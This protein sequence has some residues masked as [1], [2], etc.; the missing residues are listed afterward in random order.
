MSEAPAAAAGP[1]PLHV[2][3]RRLLG[4]V[5]RRF[6]VDTFD[7]F[8]RAVL[9]A[10]REPE[11]VPGYDLGWATAADIEG[12]DPY[13]TELDERERSAGVARLGFGHRAVAAWHAGRV[14]FTMW[15]NPRNLNVPGH[16]KRR[17]GDHQ[18]FIYK[19]YTSPD[20]R[21]KSLYKAGMRFVLAEMAAAGLTQLIGYA[22]VKKGVSRKGLAR[23]EFESLGRFRT[24]DVP[25]WRRT[26]PDS[27]LV[28][29][30][31]EALP[32]SAVLA[33]APELVS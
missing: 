21:G 2:R 23:L 20:H 8:G 17:L 32:R 9:P 7:V 28:R 16:V 26:F 4:R 5:R 3:T 10:D 1:L 22:H 30:F 27:K 25:G 18:W 11:P 19:A 29:S 31:P 24:V 33:T 13:H 6:N 14:V 12:C 15:V